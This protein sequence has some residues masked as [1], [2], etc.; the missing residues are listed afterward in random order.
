MNT[1][2]RWGRRLLGSPQAGLLLVILVLAALLTAFAGTHTDRLTGQTV[3]NFLNANT[4]I[5]TATDASFFAIMAVGATL[6]IISAGIDLSVGS[7]YALSAVAMALLLRAHTPA[8]GPA[9]VLVGLGVALGVGLVAG[10]ANGVMVV[11]LGVH[12]FIITLG[13]MWIFRGV[14]FVSSRAES[15]LVPDAL[16]SVAKAPLGLPGGLYPVPMLCML[17]VGVC[18]AVYL[19]RT[20]PGRHIFAVG[21]NPEASRYAGLD[22]TRIRLGVYV[23]SGLS[24]GL[25]AFLGASFYGS[26]SCVDATGYELY[27]IA[28]AVVGGASLSG[29]KGSAISA[30]LGALLIVLIR[31]S[32]RTLHFDQNYEWIIIGT[33]IIVAVVIDQASSR[34]AARRLARQSAQPTAA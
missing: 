5:Q 23:L 7:V 26:A 19:S 30:M 4:L 31:Q 14:A 17:A 8:G 28:S 12:P 22:L 20:V 6:V 24:A 1:R 15:V 11:G 29:G 3:N 25:A 32:I 34:L 18:G 16:T 2:T 13:T 21:G 9:A 33:A 27:V 10:L